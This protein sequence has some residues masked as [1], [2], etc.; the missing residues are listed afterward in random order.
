MY[1]PRDSRSS[2]GI[3]DGAAE[4]IVSPANPGAS[5]FNIGGRVCVGLKGRALSWTYSPGG[6]RTGQK[7]HD[8]LPW[9]Q[10]LT[11]C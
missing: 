4:L 7:L 8:V 5:V 10:Y 2:G 6:I 9:S 1:G 3:G 11:Q